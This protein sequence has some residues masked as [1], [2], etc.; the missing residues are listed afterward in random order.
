MKELWEVSVCNPKF[1]LHRLVPTKAA[2]NL[3]LAIALLTPNSSVMAQNGSDEFTLEEIKVTGTRIRGAQ[4]VGATVVGMD[5]EDINI[6]AGVTVDRVIKELPQVFDLGVSESSRG[7]S[8][9]AGNIVYA[10]S[11]NLHG[12]GPY[13]TLILIDG[14]RVVNNTRST[15]PSVIPTLGLARIEIVADGASAVYGS[16]AVAGV[17]NLIPRR[18]LNGVDTT[19]RYGVGDEFEE[20]QAGAAVGKIWSGGQVMFAIEHAFRSNLNGEDRD[21]YT[22]DQRDS[23]G[24]DY[25]VTRSSPGT[26][27]VGNTTF[28]IPLGG[29]TQET[30]TSLV[31]GTVNLY[32]DLPGQDLLPEQEYTSMNLTFTKTIT[33]RIE[34]FADGF[35]SKRDFERRP[36][37]GSAI[38]KVPNTNAFFVQPP[39]TTAGSYTI[40]YSFAD[41]LPRDAAVGSSE[42]WEITPGVRVDLP[43]GFQLE[44]L[45]TYGESDD[46]VLQSRG[47]NN[48]AL[49][50]ALASSDPATAFDPY[51]LGRTSASTL[52]GISNQIYDT[53][54]LTTFKGYEARINGPLFDLPG[55]SM[56]IAAGYEG[57]EIDVDLGNARGNPGTAVAYRYFTRRVDSGY[58]EL[59]VPIFGEPNTIPGFKRLELTAAIRYDDYDDVG[60]TTNPKI[61][62]NYS[63]IDSLSFHGS[64]GTSFRAPLITEIYGNSN[65][66]YGQTYQNPAGGAPLLGFAYSGAN[67]DLEPE[68]ATT[69]SIG[70]VIKPTENTD[71]NL[72]YFSIDYDKQIEKYL[73]NLSLLTIE[74]EFAGTGI[75]SHG[76][77]ARDRVL[78]LLAEGIPLARGSFPGGD[79]NNVTLFIDGRNNNLGV[80]VTRG[81]DF[82]VTH[83]LDTENSGTFLFKLGGTY[84]TNY[85]VAI[86]DA[87]KKIDRLNKIYN[88]LRLKARGSVTW[89]YKTFATQVAFSYV[90]EY[91][92]NAVTPTQDVDSY[93]PVDIIVRFNGDN[94]DWLG[95]FGKGLS[96]G[97]EARNAF[98]ED[99]PYVNIAQSAN[100]GGGFDPTASNPV[101]R[102]IALTLRKAF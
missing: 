35:Y 36:A 100:G 91:D 20:Y 33:N 88:P 55:G 63:P 71:I 102:T 15:D 87:G 59:L 39:G 40:D 70:T 51:G 57:Q 4:N 73:A 24:G 66:L 53:P 30:A 81:I 60:D 74:D 85:E 86:T 93:I 76:T 6:S 84:L 72:T 44:A 82:Q 79:P 27:K 95:E 101:G 92:N 61:G 77:A 56:R 94:V 3:A 89:D 38:L 98:D 1:R 52:L 29:V 34:A 37:Y 5:R 75:I 25:R 41:D 45:Y 8:G 48:G 28:A 7:Q 31:P 97:I 23:G 9:G 54:T 64:Y 46:Q 50:A 14:H 21:F 69:W 62:F 22:S 32:D 42:N 47:I 19:F 13:S 49:A 90:N 11:I 65:A 99:P 26:I 96:M 83:L 12:I 58:V 68:E 16:D 10:N 2:L 18:S 17:V 78:E 80:S 67:L 43:L